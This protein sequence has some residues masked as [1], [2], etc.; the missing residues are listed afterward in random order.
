MRHGGRAARRA[1]WGGYS[2]KRSMR[3]REAEAARVRAAVAA[4][5]VS[6]RAY[7]AGMP[8][9]A[10]P[11]RTVQLTLSFLLTETKSRPRKT[12]VISLYLSKRL[13]SLQLLASAMLPK[14]CGAQAASGGR[15][16]PERV[17][18]RRAG[19]HRREWRAR[20]L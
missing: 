14:C 16:R 6:L 4:T 5:L 9:C 17:R 20:S 7:T 18:R 11:R 15:R 1:G 10:V 3:R 8:C 19:T 12:D 2:M 13:A